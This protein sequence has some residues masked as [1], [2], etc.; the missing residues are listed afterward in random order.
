MAKDKPAMVSDLEPLKK[1]LATLK[2]RV[3]KLQKRL[4]YIE[5]LLKQAHIMSK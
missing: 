3:T 2:G 5:E 1:E 4:D